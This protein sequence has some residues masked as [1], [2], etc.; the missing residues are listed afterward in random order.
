MLGFILSGELYS[1]VWVGQ[2]LLPVPLFP[3]LSPGFLLYW[4]VPTENTL[5]VHRH[6]ILY[7]HRYLVQSEDYIILN[8]NLRLVF[9]EQFGNLKVFVLKSPH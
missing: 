8:I 4:P 9:Q 2:S 6:T 1:H 5:P 3:A 7:E